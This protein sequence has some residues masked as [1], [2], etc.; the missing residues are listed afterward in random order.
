MCYQNDKN[1][2]AHPL[3]LDSPRKKTL[4]NSDT[5][6]VGDFSAGAGG[7]SSEEISSASSL[8]L[9]SH[10]K[11][12]VGIGVGTKFIMNKYALCS[13]YLLVNYVKILL[14]GFL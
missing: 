14:K 9:V 12:C 3:L 10:S 6:G 2:S 1:Y 7:L 13:Q 8:S 5:S 11:S 4:V